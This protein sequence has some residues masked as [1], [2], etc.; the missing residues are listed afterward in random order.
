VVLEDGAEELPGLAA[1]LSTLAVAG[2]EAIVVDRTASFDENRRVLRWVARHVA[3]RPRHCS[4][5]GV[6]DPIRAAF[7]LASCEKVIVAA[8]EVRYAP[9]DVDSICALLDAHEVVEPQ[10]YLEPL[11]WWG[12]IDAGRMLLH[13][14]L[15]PL[16]D[17]GGTFAF[18][19]SAIRGLRVIDGAVTD[20]PVRRLAAQGAEVH[21]AFALFVRRLPPLLGD[22]IRER[23]RLADDD[24]SMPVKSAFFFALLPIALLLVLF[25][26]LRLA[27]G[28]AGAVA[29]GSVALALRGRV[30]A[31]PFFPLRACLFAPLWVFERAVSVYWALFRK[32][33]GQ[34]A[35]P[36]RPEVV[37]GRALARPERSA[38]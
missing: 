12:G 28:Y 20:D 34:P 33:R 32:L 4:F 38:G 37:E 21:S 7:D 16:P 26:G 3:P 10:D 15:E 36:R 13:R 1:Y 23:P 14:G 17:H 2:C 29:F 25:G 18:R 9:P 11:P 19:K 27:G 35:E 8:P 31:A 30:G 5:S 22:W 24:F 6:I